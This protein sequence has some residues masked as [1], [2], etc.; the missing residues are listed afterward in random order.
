MSNGLGQYD[1][2]SLLDTLYLLKHTKADISEEVIRRNR[3]VI[4]DELRSRGLEEIL[5]FLVKEVEG[6]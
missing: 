4:I 5:M 3:K 6:D 2:E 1:I